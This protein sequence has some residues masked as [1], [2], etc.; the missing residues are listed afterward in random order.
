MEDTRISD[1]RSSKV[2]EVLESRSLY[3]NASSEKY[4]IYNSIV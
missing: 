3:S 1:A 2:T 4:F